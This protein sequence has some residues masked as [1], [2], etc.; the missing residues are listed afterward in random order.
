MERAGITR[1]HRNGL[2][3]V[4]SDPVALYS[5]CA[6]QNLLLLCG[7][8]S[9]LLDFSFGLTKK[10]EKHNSLLNASVISDKAKISY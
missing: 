9:A 8:E 4:I 7:L 3:H 2:L 1:W 10:E 6:D 5:A